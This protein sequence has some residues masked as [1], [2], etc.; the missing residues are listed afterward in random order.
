MSSR[1]TLLT[2]YTAYLLELIVGP[3]EAQQRYGRGATRVAR[4][5]EAV[6]L[7]AVRAPALHLEQLRLRDLHVRDRAVREHV[8]LRVS[9]EC[10]VDN[11]DASTQR[12]AD[13]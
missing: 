7:G 10:L 4:V 2:T 12:R 13:R 8:V 5:G 11:S 3:Q 9:V 6:R 1:L